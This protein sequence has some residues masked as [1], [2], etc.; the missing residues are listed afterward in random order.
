VAAIG[1]RGRGGCGDWGR[2]S[3]MAPR[4]RSI[5]NQE[6]EA[7][8]GETAE[9]G[10]GGDA[11]GGGGGRV[12]G[13]GEETTGGGLVVW[14]RVCFSLSLQRDISGRAQSPCDTWPNR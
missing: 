11:S 3:L 13:F 8:R 4:G 9:E 14:G 1:E 12:G 7:G 5:A 6:E 10:A 2:D